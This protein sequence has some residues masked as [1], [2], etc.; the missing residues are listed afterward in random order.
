MKRN[1][2]KRE[3]KSDGN[4]TLFGSPHSY[5]WMDLEVIILIWQKNKSDYL[6]RL[7]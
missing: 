1:E 4:G 5:T 3:R 2:V 7:F 6:K